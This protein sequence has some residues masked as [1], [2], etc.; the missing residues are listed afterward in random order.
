MKIGL[1]IC[2]HAMEQ[3][4]KTH[5]DYAEWFQTLLAGHGFDFDTYNVVDMEFPTDVRAADGWLVSGS[6]HGA[7]EDHPFI[8]PLEG[9]IRNAYV[10]PVPIVG[11]C[12]GHQLI[13]Q[14]LGGKV[15]KFKGGWAVGRQNY[16]FE[17]HGDVALNAW[18][19]DQVMEL[20]DDARVIASND[21]CKNAGLVYGDSIYTIQPHPEFSNPIIADYITL[22]RD[23][24]VYDD[25]MMDRAIANTKIPNDAALFSDSIA[26]FFK[27]PREAKNG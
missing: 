5:G 6:A 26:A 1:L 10:A 7:Y 8:P 27:Q 11:V 3:V 13:A 25:A 2:G 22:R 12:F 15:E 19:Q 9:F 14:A 18:H 4:A 17:G 23:P 20:P 21:F 16:T 24:A